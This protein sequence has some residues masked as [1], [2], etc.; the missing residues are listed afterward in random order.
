MNT[1]F[2]LGRRCLFAAGLY[3][4][5][6]SENRDLQKSRDGGVLE[7]VSDLFEELIDR[8]GEPPKAVLNLMT[9]A[10]LKVYG[11]NYGIESII[12][13]GDEITLKVEERRRTDIELSKLKAMEQ[14]FQGRMVNAINSQQLLIKFKIRGLDE[15]AL[16]ALME[17]FLLQYKEAT[18]S[19]GELQDVAP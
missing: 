13:R 11:R 8:F 16:L 12:R 9:V 3:L 5:Q 19:K 4:R 17:Q 18:K 6:Y 2:D 1:Q 7:D 10:R 14:K 15:N